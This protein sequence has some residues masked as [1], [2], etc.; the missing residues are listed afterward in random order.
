MRR[1][2]PPL[3]ARGVRLRDNAAAQVVAALA[4]KPWMAPAEAVA[5]AV[6]YA[7]ALAREMARYDETDLPRRRG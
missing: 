2:A 7:R 4:T 1:P 5:L 3:S 6:V